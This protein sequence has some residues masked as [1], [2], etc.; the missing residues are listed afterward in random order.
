MSLQRLD[1]ILVSIMNGRTVTVHLLNG[2]TVASR[3]W[4]PNWDET[5]NIHPN[6]VCFIR[7]LNVKKKKHKDRKCIVT[8]KARAGLVQVKFVDDGRYGYVNAA[9]LVP[10]NSIA[11]IQEMA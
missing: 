3:Y 10:E 8:G 7:S 5:F 1:D 9:D 4:K 6:T 2:G 11:D